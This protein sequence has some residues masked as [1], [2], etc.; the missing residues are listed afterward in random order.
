MYGGWKHAFNDD[1]GTDVGV[2]LLLLPGQ[3]T[4]TGFTRANTTELYIAGNWKWVSL[5]F[6]DSLGNTFGVPD[7]HN[8]WYLN[9]TANI[10][11]NE[12]WTILTHV[13]RQEYHGSNNGVS[14]SQLNYTDRRLG[15]SYTINKSTPSA[16]TGPIPTTRPRHTRLPARTSAN[17][18]G[19]STCKRRSDRAAHANE[20][21]NPGLTTTV[22]SGKSNGLHLHRSDR[23]IFRRVS[24]TD[25][26]LRV[27]DGKGR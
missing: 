5:K 18:R 8:A 3:I 27:P 22:F 6:S 20:H 2:L 10:P 4:A 14:N 13:G 9:L 15:V 7:S 19:R 23:R 1:R 25:S 12:Q 16:R 21:A 11:I 26:L 24:G 17:P